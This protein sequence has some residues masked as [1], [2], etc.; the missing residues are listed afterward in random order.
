MVKN[1]YG[2]VYI[3]TNT[4]N[5]KKY[6]GITTKKNGFNGRYNAIGV[7]MERVF[8][9]LNNRAEIGYYCNEHLLRS[10]IKYG[11]NNFK[12]IEEFDIA[13]SKD[14]LQEK[15][16][17]WI[18]YFKSNDFNKGYNNTN[19]GEGLEG[20]TQNF[21]SKLKRRITKAKRINFLLEYWYNERLKW[22]NKHLYIWDYDDGLSQDQK[23]LLCNKLGG[24][25]TKFCKICGIEYYRSGKGNYC[26]ICGDDKFLNE[27]RV[28]KEEIKNLI[29]KQKSA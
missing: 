22:E 9:Y 28:Y 16:R 13:S 26:K 12:V 11:I 14:E 29:I 2:I 3:I 7:G 5:D 21:I 15:E 19:G 24:V 4:I 27:C 25:K 8:N 10:I 18:E 23:H 6:V 20:C 1:K 17:Y